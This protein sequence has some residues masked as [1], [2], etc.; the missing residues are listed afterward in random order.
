MRLNRIDLQTD[1]NFLLDA[2]S[3]ELEQDYSSHDQGPSCQDT[4]KYMTCLGIA[5][6]MQVSEKNN[7]LFVNVLGEIPMSIAFCLA[8]VRLRPQVPLSYHVQR[9]YTSHDQAHADKSIPRF[10]PAAARLI[11]LPK[12]ARHNDLG[13]P[14]LLI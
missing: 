13:R 2:R 6:D 12:K 4:C 11:L 8:G 1:C 7:L 10:S 3:Y 14:T 5:S 9:M